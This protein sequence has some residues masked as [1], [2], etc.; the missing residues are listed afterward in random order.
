M[1]N[2]SFF[3]TSTLEVA[4]KLIGT[5]LEFGRCRGR[6]VEVEAYTDDPASHGYRRTDRS[7]IM[8]ETCAHV[9]VYFIY[10]MYYCL[11]ITTDKSHA[12][13]VLIRALE[14]LRGISLM[15]K[16]RGVE[17]ARRLCN[18]PGKLCQALGITLV[19][20]GTKIGD[21]I[22]LYRG[23]YT[24]VSSSPRIGI[25]KATDLHWRFFETDNP[26][27]SR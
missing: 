25:T 3:A 1:L 14:P 27:V 13:A 21:Q 2:S 7:E 16:R 22:K 11:N 8:F 26:F 5:I 12:G 17:D 19:Q 6:I 18:G 23:T 4:P 24:S 10:G 20:N 9:Y 15:K